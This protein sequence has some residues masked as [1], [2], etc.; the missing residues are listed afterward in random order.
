[1]ASEFCSGECPTAEQIEEVT[2]EDARKLKKDFCDEECSADEIKTK[3]CDADC[4][5]CKKQTTGGEECKD[6]DISDYCDNNCEDS[7][8]VDT[9]KHCPDGQGG[10]DCSKSVDDY[11]DGKYGSCVF[12]KDEY[13][14]TKSGGGY[15]KDIMCDGVCTGDVIRDCDECGCD[16]DNAGS[17]VKKAK[18]LFSRDGKLLKSRDEESPCKECEGEELNFAGIFCDGKCP[19]TEG[20]KG[21]TPENSVFSYCGEKGGCPGQKKS[22]CT[23]GC[24]G[25]NCIPEDECAKVTGDPHIVTFFGEKFEL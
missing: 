4:S 1:M 13:C 10:Y 9:D 17:C 19:E 2:G 5:K 14:C 15:S 21:D 16:P 20:A 12:P 24:D 23:C 18:M 7:N 22:E 8:K 11:C 6:L 3:Y 25:L